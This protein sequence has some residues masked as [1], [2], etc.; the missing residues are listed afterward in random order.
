VNAGPGT[1]DPAARRDE[2]LAYWPGADTLER[3]AVLRDLLRK[4]H[5]PVSVQAAVLGDEPY[6]EVLWRRLT[7]DMGAAAILVPESL[8]GLGLGYEDFAVVAGELGRVLYTG[9]FFGSAVLALAA[10]LSL[11]RTQ[12]GAGPGDDAQSGDGARL[13]AAGTGAAAALIEQIAEGHLV[14][15]LAFLDSRGRWDSGQPGVAAVESAGGWQLTGR[16]HLVVNAAQAQV[17]CVLATAGAELSLFAVRAADVGVTPVESIDLT[18]GLGTVTL[19]GAPATRLGRGAAARDAVTAA[20][21][22][23]RLAIAAESVAGAEAALRLMVDYA[24]SRRQFGRP[25]GS[26]QAIKHKCAD[27]LIAVE[28]AKATVS[29][30]SWALDDGSP[31]AAPAVLAAKIAATEAFV[32]VAADCIQVHGTYGYTREALSQS[33]YRR[34]RWLSVFLGSA[35]EDS[36]ALASLLG[37]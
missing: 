2:P 10:L 27:A 35:D 13:G 17:F 25:I 37:V 31:E 12:D 14:A 9:P 30:A 18:R 36:Q 16:H 20:V 8:G 5:D 6:D 4:Q 23:G 33:Y 19:E 1:A 22:L 26:F 15:T 29:Y 21:G 28:E 11:A 32:K 34:A 3:R 24:N 7:S